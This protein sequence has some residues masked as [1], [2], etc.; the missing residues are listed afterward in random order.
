MDIKRGQW[1]GKDREEGK[2]GLGRRTLTC[3]WIPR[4][5][6]WKAPFSLRGV[7][8]N[9]SV[10][11]LS[12]SL[13]F[14]FYTLTHR[15]PFLHTHHAPHPS[16]PPL[17]IKSYTGVQ[18]CGIVSLTILFSFDCDIYIYIACKYWETQLKLSL[19]FD[20]CLCAGQKGGQQSAG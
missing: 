20:A 14:F 7:E 8:F 2:V 18:K 19:A 4:P 5:L 17:N 1:W 3:M 16:D 13:S 9:V 6:A 12:L 15:H 11:L 10:H